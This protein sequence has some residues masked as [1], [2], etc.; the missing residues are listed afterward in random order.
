MVNPS[1]EITMKR[2]ILVLFA[3]LVSTLQ[4][5]SAIE[6]KSEK[7]SIPFCVSLTECV[8]FNIQGALKRF[9]DSSLGN[10]DEYMDLIHSNIKFALAATFFGGS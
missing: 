9:D 4:Y 10:P 3:F 2:S 7:F 1:V 6:E 5:A 8:E